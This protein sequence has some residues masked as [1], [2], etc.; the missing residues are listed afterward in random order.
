MTWDFDGLSIDVG[1][2]FT[3]PSHDRLEAA[4]VAAGLA[5]D[6]AQFWDGHYAA[7]HAVDE[8][9]SAPETFGDY[10]PGF[11][12]FVGF[13]GDDHAAAVAALAP[14]FGPSGLWCE[15]VTESIDGLRE[16]HTAG[17]RIVVLSNADGT[18]E[19]LLRRVG[20][21]QVGP[22]PGVP[23]EAIIDSGSV[24]FAKPDPR[25]FAVAAGA[26]GLPPE[27]VLHVGDSVHY[28]VDGALAAGL[29]AAHFDPSERCRRTDHP[30]VRRLAELVPRDQTP[31]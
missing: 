2:V 25:I 14:M 11:C 5:V 8:A 9:R 22:G 23:V 27:R 18:I 4:L 15:P 3:V 28:D 12:H 1:G 24:G 16:L 7:M 20:V 30:H 29:Q 31:G 10:V 6:R 21:C 17:V 19:D 13:D 26:L